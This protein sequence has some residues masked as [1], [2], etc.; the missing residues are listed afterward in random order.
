MRQNR[1][2]LPEVCPVPIP[3]KRIDRE[4]GLRVT[5]ELPACPGLRRLS[6]YYRRLLQGLE[7]ATPPPDLSAGFRLRVWYTA[8]SPAFGLCRIRLEVEAEA[9]LR[10]FPVCR[11][12]AVWNLRT[13]FP[14][15]PGLLCQAPRRVLLRWLAEVVERRSRSG[16]VL[17]ESD[18]AARLPAAYVPWQL[19]WSEDSP[20]LFLQPMTISAPAEGFPVFPIPQEFLQNTVFSCFAPAAVV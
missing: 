5:G 9:E 19:L 18:A 17:Y 2:K 6:A 1:S 12:E 4:G 11:D 14:L 16:L 15:P 13:G 8:D 3:E 10:R 7:S 20:A